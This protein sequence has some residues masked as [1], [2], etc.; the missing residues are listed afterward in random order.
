MSPGWLADRSSEEIFQPG[1]AGPGDETGQE[2]HAVQEQ[3]RYGQQPG[4]GPALQAGQHPEERSTT[5]RDGRQA[6]LP[7]GGGG[8]AEGQ[9]PGGGLLCQLHHVQT[10]NKN[11]PRRQNYPTGK[12]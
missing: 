8:G 1:A 11:F 5:G 3:V 9:Q 10:N 4:D 12:D 7:L 6:G 2:D